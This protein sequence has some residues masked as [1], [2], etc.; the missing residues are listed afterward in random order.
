VF[1]R[2]FEEVATRCK[3]AGLVGDEGL[4]IDPSMIAADACPARKVDGTLAA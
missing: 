1:H 4:A 2:L 3:R